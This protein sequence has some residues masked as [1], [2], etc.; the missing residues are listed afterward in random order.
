MH[1][2]M[3]RCIHEATPQQHH[4]AGWP[5]S[6]LCWHLPF[7]P[8]TRAFGCWEVLMGALQRMTTS[9]GTCESPAGCKELISWQEVP[10][11]MGGDP[12]EFPDHPGESALEANLHGARDPAWPGSSCSESVE[13]FRTNWKGFP[14]TCSQE[15]GRSRW[16][17]V[18]HKLE[19]FRLFGLPGFKEFR[20][21]A[22]LGTLAKFTGLP[23]SLRTHEM[24]HIFLLSFGTPAL[25]WTL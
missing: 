6:V 15:S 10:L 9:P 7:G 1:E 21:K 8:W 16:L 2:W 24:L 12:L 25:S 17:T 5:V 14:L 22:I 23:L 13:C 18:W 11:F 20:A 19:L 4:L 3:P